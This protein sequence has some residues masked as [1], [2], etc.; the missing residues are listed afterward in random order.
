MVTTNEVPSSRWGIWKLAAR[1]WTLPAAAAPVLV[2]GGL[3]LAEGQFRPLVALV[4]LVVAL[5]LQVGVNFVNDVQD[6]QRGADQMGERLGPPRVTTEGWLMPAEVWGGTWVVFG[7]TALLGLYLVWVGGWPI[8]GIGVAS[9]VAA[10]AYTGGPFPLG[11]H[12]LGEV[13]VFLFFGLFAV[14][15]TY[16][17]QTG[18]LSP[19]AVWAGAF[20]GSLAAAILVVNN[21]RDLEND[22]RAGK[23][24]LAVC[25]GRQG[26]QVEY[27]LLLGL[28]YLTPIGLWLA[29][30]APLGVLAVWLSA[31]LMVKALRQFYTLQG[32]ALNRA[33]AVTG[34]VELAYGVLLA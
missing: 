24:T 14:G 28:P 1:P 21:Y 6:Y 18:A 34:K 22:R 27:T 30:A 5:L 4:T 12:N 8:L 3:A 9:V 13:F 20:M 19:L 33:L 17:L 7:A 15:G 2:G 32:R 16:Y 23:H 29:G 11:Y 10:L 26:T 25:L 31:P